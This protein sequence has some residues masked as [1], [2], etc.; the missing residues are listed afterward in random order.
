MNII[1]RILQNQLELNDCIDSY[2][3]W[4]NINKEIF[5]DEK[6]KYQ[7]KYIRKEKPCNCHPGTCCHFEG[8]IV[9]NSQKKVYLKK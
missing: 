3:Y 9:V 8:V 2:G 7:V 4:S 6:G 1:F 5:E